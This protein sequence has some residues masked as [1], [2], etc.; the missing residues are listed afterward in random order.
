MVIAAVKGDLRLFIPRMD[1]GWS[2]LKEV[3]PREEGQPHALHEDGQVAAAPR[4]VVPHPRQ[5]RLVHLLLG[6]HRDGVAGDQLS[7]LNGRSGVVVQMVAW[8]SQQSVNMTFFDNIC[9]CHHIIRLIFSHIIQLVKST[10]RRNP[11][12][13]EEFLKLINSCYKKQKT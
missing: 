13:V 8:V 9:K 3:L 10:N 2:S 4:H 1:T 6:G 12:L 11:G 7:H 5:H